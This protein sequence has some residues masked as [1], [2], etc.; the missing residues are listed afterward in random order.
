MCVCGGGDYPKRNRK[1]NLLTSSFVF[2]PLEH[3]FSL[4]PLRI[5]TSFKGA[6]DNHQ[7]VIAAL[8]FGV[9]SKLHSTLN[10]GVVNLRWRWGSGQV[11]V[12]GIGPIKDTSIVFKAINVG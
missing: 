2:S 12:G 8:T 1:Q 10:E 11:G 4:R 6:L 7:S 9:L 3:T 5:R